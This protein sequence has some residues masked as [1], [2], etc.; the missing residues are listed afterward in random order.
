MGLPTT[1]AYVIAA[2]I[3]APSL[4]KLGLDALTSHLFVFYF[5][6]LSAIT[7]PVAL[8]AYAGAGLAKTSPMT[9]AVE[10]CKLGFAGF[11]V[12]FAFC[13]NPAMMLQGNIIEVLEIVFFAIVG[14]AVMSAGF[15]GWLLWRLNILERWIFIVGGLLM[16]V[17]ELISSLIGLAIVILLIV[18]NM[19]KWKT[20][21]TTA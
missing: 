10:A 8:A 1:A 19:R 15:Q 4:I 14:V 3:L 6:C 20:A 16:F 13:Y 18:I 5:A 11:M 17:P 9:T 12:P 21:K 7:P 2:S